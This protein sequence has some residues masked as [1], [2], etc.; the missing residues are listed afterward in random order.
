MSYKE[1]RTYAAD[2]EGMGSAASVGR[3]G[4]WGP[5]VKM[6]KANASNNVLRAG[7]LTVYMAD[8][9]NMTISTSSILR[10]WDSNGTSIA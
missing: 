6:L 10:G 7:Y 3:C 4:I 9:T 8:G 1:E 2:W 5:E